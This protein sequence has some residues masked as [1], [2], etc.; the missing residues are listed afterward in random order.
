[1]R[2]AAPRLA[3]RG[4]AENGGTGLALQTVM[5][6]LR[7]RRV[8]NSIRFVL[9]EC[10]PPIVRE[11]RGLNALIAKLWFG[12]KIDL[13][14][15]EKAFTLPASEFAAAYARLPATAR[16]FR[17]SDTTSEQARAIVAATVGPR[18]LEVGCG[19]GMVTQ[20][21]VERG[22]DVTASDIGEDGLVA[23][24]RRAGRRGSVQVVSAALPAL[25]FSDRE[26]DSVV[27]AHTLEHIPRV[28]QAAAE[29]TR[30]ARRRLLV[31]VPRQR[32]YRYTTDYHLHFFQSAAPLVAMI[33][34]DQS[35][36]RLVDGDWF[37]VGDRREGDFAAARG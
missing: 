30:V 25:P 15:K 3:Y 21:L 32:Y 34:L 37:Y 23:T 22:F 24:R 27:C 35:T 6:R 11:N 2:I 16:R 4:L 31:V 7:S 12:G 14:F 13:D 10:L 26:F 17:D 28:W 36:V 29:L 1:V 9:D 19:N 8:T 18:V 20:L 33:G 5:R